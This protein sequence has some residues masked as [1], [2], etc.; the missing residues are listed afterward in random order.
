MHIIAQDASLL[1]LIQHY[2]NT[3]GTSYSMYYLAIWSN[4]ACIYYVNMGQVQ[5]AWDVHNKVY[6]LAN[7]GLCSIAFVKQ[8]LHHFVFVTAYVA[9]QPDAGDEVR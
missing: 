5:E 9:Y 1:L 3:K 4:K 7:R 6:I 2:T 8:T